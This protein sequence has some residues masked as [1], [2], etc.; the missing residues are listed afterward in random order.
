MRQIIILNPQYFR[1]RATCYLLGKLVAT[2]KR[3]HSVSPLHGHDEELTASTYTD[4][5]H[6]YLTQHIAVQAQRGDT[7]SSVT[8]QAGDDH[9]GLETQMY[10]T[11]TEYAMHVTFHYYMLILLLIY[12]VHFCRLLQSDNKTRVC[13]YLPYPLLCLEF[14]LLSFILSDFSLTLSFPVFFSIFLSLKL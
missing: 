7:Q 6:L 5:Q 4:Q 12:I 8:I 11:D 14:H 13:N 2:T 10:V 9:G 1:T 3:M